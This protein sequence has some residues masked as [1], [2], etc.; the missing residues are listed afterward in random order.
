MTVE[1]MTFTSHRDGE[2]EWITVNGFP[3]EIDV[4]VQLIECAHPPQGARF[5]FLE[6]GLFGIQVA[7]GLASYRVT[8]A[9][10]GNLIMRR[11]C[12]ELRD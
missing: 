6:S 7:N 10:G 4:S 9:R 8:G 11:V 1:P 2:R 12:G 3:D 5:E